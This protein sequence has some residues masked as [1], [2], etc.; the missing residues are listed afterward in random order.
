MRGL[1]KKATQSHP[2]VPPIS[3]ITSPAPN[4]APIEPEL[5]IDVPGIFEI[6]NR[7]RNYTSYNFTSP[8]DGSRKRRTP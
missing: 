1:R 5:V 7:S 8:I 2:N 4:V 6:Q 3:T